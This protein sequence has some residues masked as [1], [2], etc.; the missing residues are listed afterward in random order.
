MT[1]APW[2]LA[3]FSFFAVVR[4]SKRLKS[5]SVEAKGSR[6]ESSNKIARACNLYAKKFGFVR[7]ENGYVQ[8]FV[9]HARCDKIQRA[10]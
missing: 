2:S 3:G 4:S 7:G 8:A 5:E 10:I 9:V 1:A 6:G